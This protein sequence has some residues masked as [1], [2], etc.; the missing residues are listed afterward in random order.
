M[1]FYSLGVQT[2]QALWFTALLDAGGHASCVQELD[3]AVEIKQ[4]S[5]F[6]H[7]IQKK[8]TCN[9]LHIVLI[10]GSHST[11]K[12]GYLMKHLFLLI[13]HAETFEW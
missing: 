9:M 7:H 4:F 3:G 1:A 10:L 11:V 8:K 12:S 6:T 2:S 13:P 5:V